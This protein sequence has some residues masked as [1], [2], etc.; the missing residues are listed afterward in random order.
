MKKESKGND[1]AL[2][3][4]CSGSWYVMRFRIGD[5]CF[6]ERVGGPY[7]LGSSRAH[8]LISEIHPSQQL[9]LFFCYVRRLLYA[10]LQVCDK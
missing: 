7:Q 9:S 8:N 10:S 2:T 3:P 5:V 1:K 4:S 6:T